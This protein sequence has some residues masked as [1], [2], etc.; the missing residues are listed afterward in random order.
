M[1]F[2]DEVIH[3]KRMDQ[4]NPISYRSLLVLLDNRL[5][6]LLHV[7]GISLGKF[8]QESSTVKGYFDAENIPSNNVGISYMVSILALYLHNTCYSLAD[9]WCYC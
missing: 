6:L 3:R 8:L 4:R 7:N 5:D 2:A 9:A 1:G